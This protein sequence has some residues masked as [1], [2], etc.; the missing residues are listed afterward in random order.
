[1]LSSLRSSPCSWK[2][3]NAG[4]AGL[5]MGRKPTD[6]R[7]RRKKEELR[8]LG[9]VAAF[10]IVAGGLVIGAVYGPRAIALG[11]TCLVLGVGT[12]GLLWI[13]LSAIERLSG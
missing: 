10:F 1:M 2:R 13:L 8:L 4:S 6:R 3:R 5:I 7:A 12:L 9:A 11:L